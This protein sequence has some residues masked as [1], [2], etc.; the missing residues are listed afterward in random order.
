MTKAQNYRDICIHIHLHYLYIPLFYK[1]VDLHIHLH[2]YSLILLYRDDNLSKKWKEFNIVQYFC[3]EYDK[4]QLCR[5]SIFACFY[6]KNIRIF[7]IRSLYLQNSR[8][9]SS[10]EDF[11]KHRFDR[12]YSHCPVMSIR[13]YQ[14][15][16]AISMLLL[17][18]L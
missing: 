14:C 3:F 15:K 13:Q 1:F 12:H 2:Q 16:P 9:E 6:S 8:I 5:K 7:G 11:C 17:M 18:G 4:I 10:P